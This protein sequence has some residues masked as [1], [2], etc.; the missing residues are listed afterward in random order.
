MWSEYL[1]LMVILEGRK[2]FYQVSFEYL[3][4]YLIWVWGL[5]L[6]SGNSGI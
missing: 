1:V 5:L 2:E 4:I 3:D 6:M